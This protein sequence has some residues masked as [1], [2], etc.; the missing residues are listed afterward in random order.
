M[1][2]SDKTPDS[3]EDQSPEQ[4]QSTPPDALSRTPDELKQEEQDTQAESQTAASNEDT[5]PKTANKQRF[6]AV[7]RFFAKVN[8][9]FL[10]FFLLVAIGA[11][12]TTVNYLNS[13]K[14]TPPP[15]LAS[16]ELT[17][18]ALRDLASKS[19][20]VGNTSQTLNV[21]GNMVVAGQTLMR[22]N[23]DIAGNLLTGGSIQ[24]P[25]LTISG[26]STLGETQIDRLQ[27][28]NDT[29][30]QGETSLQNVSVAGTSSFSGAMTASQITVTRLVMSGNAS[31]EVPN[32]I[33]FTGATPSRRI[34]SSVLGSGGSAS[35]NGSD[36]AGTVNINTGNS[37]KPGCFVDITF[38]TPYPSRPHVIISPVGAAAGRTNYYVNRSNTN[39]SICSANAAPANQSFAFD[40][41]ISY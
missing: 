19:V 36:T 13:K 37:P 12:I 5:P 4:V 32:H 11:I 26:Q 21:Q 38:N 2:T 27:V 39:F 24:G 35:I 16:Q 34:D 9:Y 15:D 33:S 31:L 29:T 18:E 20:T 30:I 1:D 17:E 7:K 8:L 28:A 25:T 22:G 6:A 14:E 10:M 40:Y 41:F 23:V 3:T